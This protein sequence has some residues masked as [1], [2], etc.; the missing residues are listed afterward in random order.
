MKIVLATGSYP[1]DV[2]GVGDYVHCLYN[3]LVSKGVEVEVMAS[4]DWSVTAMPNL[5]SGLKNN[6][7]HI[8]YPSVGY[9]YKLGPQFLSLLVRSVVTL[10]EFNK[11]H[12]L[13]RASS[14]PFGLRARWVVFTSESERQAALRRMPWLRTR[15]DVIPVGSNIYPRPR[16]SDRTVEEI[17]YFGLI[18]PKKGLEHVVELAAL[19]REKDLPFR[20]RVIGSV[21]PELQGFAQTL[22]SKSHGLPMAW[23]LNRPP[24]E[25]AEL[26]SHAFVAY[27]P[28]P[29][30]AS[31]RRGS[32]KAVLAAGVPCISTQGTDT[33]SPLRA[34][35]L[36]GETLEEVLSTAQ[37]LAHDRAMW[38]EW[39]AKGI[40]YAKSFDWAIIADRH[41]ALYERVEELA[42][43]R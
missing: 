24:E 21:V 8:Q 12:W 26:L 15:S 13:R 35:I 33:S 18:V 10:H 9:G 34:A 22:I 42:S 40:E 36:C 39:S 43:R 23:T 2:C 30:G 19:I 27:L 37:Q 3:A 14:F 6:I 7:L 17:V 31:E 25:V 16:S 20:I 1:P 5:A 11:V 29:N 4:D 38:D 41:I 32:L 28:F